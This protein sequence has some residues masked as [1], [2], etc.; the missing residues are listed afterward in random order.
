L[1]NLAYR[2][3]IFSIDFLCQISMPGKVTMYLF[4]VGLVSQVKLNCW[5]CLLLL[6]EMEY[7]KF[8]T[9]QKSLIIFYFCLFSQLVWSVILQ[10]IWGKCLFVF[11][12]LCIIHNFFTS[13]SWNGWDNMPICSTNGEH[14]KMANVAE[15]LQNFFIS[16]QGK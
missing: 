13:V 14:R 8:G 10:V 1:L 6:E 2:N 12:A 4:I 11:L 16:F 5:S 7:L 9:K 3:W 15:T